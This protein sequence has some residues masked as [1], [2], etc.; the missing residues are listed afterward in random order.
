MNAVAVLLCLTVIILVIL[1]LG[2]Y[3]MKIRLV[4][5]VLLID[6]EFIIA[7]ILDV[8]LVDLFLIW[9]FRK[10]KEDKKK[11]LKNEGGGKLSNMSYYP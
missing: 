3:F 1:I 2:I 4:Y 11:L 9:R 8:L 6:Q 7:N 10:S 5:F